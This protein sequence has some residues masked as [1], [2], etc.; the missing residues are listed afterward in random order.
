MTRHLNIWRLQL[1]Y[2]PRW[3]LAFYRGGRTW[4][5]PI[6]RWVVYVWP[7]EVRCFR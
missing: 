3:T 1:V 2:W 7:V 6:Y 4:A 5:S